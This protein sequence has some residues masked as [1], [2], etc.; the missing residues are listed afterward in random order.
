M[1]M[2]R[3]FVF[4]ACCECAIVLLLSLWLSSCAG[5]VE[6]FERKYWARRLAEN[7]AVSTDYLRQLE[8]IKYGNQATIRPDSE[9]IFDH[10]LGYVRI[11]PWRIAFWGCVGI[12]FACFLC[13]AII[14]ALLWGWP[15]WMASAARV[16]PA[17]LETA[18]PT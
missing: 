14:I 18:K 11:S 16:S 10:V 15:T 2:K 9:M 7:H 8:R 12:Y 5:S 1:T 6:R 17:T 13:R 4:S 3:T